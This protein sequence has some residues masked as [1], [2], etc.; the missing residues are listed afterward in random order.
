MKDLIDNLV[1]QA[2]IT[3]AQAAKV[4]DVLKSFVADKLPEPI[5]STVLAALSGENVSAAA[6]QAKGLLG[7]IAGKLF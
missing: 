4:A 7:S 1:K 6:D 2:D 3:P 5:K